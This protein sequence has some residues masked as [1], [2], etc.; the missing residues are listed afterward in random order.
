[1][2][3]FAIDYYYNQ[4]ET[5]E[6]DLKAIK[7]RK[8]E[9]EGEII[10]NFRD[11]FKEKFGQ[12]NEPFG[13]VSLHYGEFEIGYTIPKSVDW[14]QDKLAEIYKMIGE[15]EDPSV[16]IKVKYDVS[17]TAYKSW[18]EDVRKVFDAARTVKDGSAK[19]EVK[20]GETK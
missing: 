18:P 5:I 7:A 10:E 14:D 11:V 3:N 20:K 17:E 13:K 12:K 4:L 15:H 16:Y 9:L 1:M 6:A 8:K 2:K 19:L